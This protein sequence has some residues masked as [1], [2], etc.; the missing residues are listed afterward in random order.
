MVTTTTQ[1]YQAYTFISNWRLSLYYSIMRIAAGRRWFN[2]PI[3]VCDLV[4]PWKTDRMLRDWQ[5]K[6]G[7]AAKER[8]EWRERKRDG[9]SRATYEKFEVAI[10]HFT[11]YLN[12]PVVSRYTQIQISRDIVLNYT[13]FYILIYKFFF[14]KNS[15]RFRYWKYCMI[16]KE[17]N[18]AS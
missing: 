12:W 8:R 18:N 15:M 11:E 5:R 13:I 9:E 14:L 6:P 17:T 2:D 7:V 10:G 3:S 1:A 4:W 16:I